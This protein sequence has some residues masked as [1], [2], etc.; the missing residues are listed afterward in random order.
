MSSLDNRPGPFQ[1]R[2][3]PGWRTLDALIA[4][5]DV[6]SFAHPSPPL[7]TLVCRGASRRLGNTQ[8]GFVG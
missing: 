4:T 3:V 7:P 2:I 1:V 5:V 8:T 6:D